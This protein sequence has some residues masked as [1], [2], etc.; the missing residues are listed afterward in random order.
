MPENH[1]E[2][3]M[4]QRQTR[5]RS[6]EQ[7]APGAQPISSHFFSTRGGK[8]YSMPIVEMRKL[9]LREKRDSLQGHS[10]ARGKAATQPQAGGSC[11]QGRWEVP[12]GGKSPRPR[13]GAANKEPWQRSLCFDDS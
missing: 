10:A 3:G 4:H 2:V 13:G 5:R 6:R 12:K 11:P 8:E 9:R 7:P 1:Q